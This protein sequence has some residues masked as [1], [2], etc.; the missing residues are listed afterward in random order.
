MDNIRKYLEAKGDKESFLNN[1]VN[2]IKILRE[3]KIDYTAIIY[4]ISVALRT[5]VKAYDIEAGIIKKG[6]KIKVSKGIHRKGLHTDEFQRN[7]AYP[8]GTE[9]KV[10][11]FSAS[12]EFYINFEK[13]AEWIGSYS[14]PY[15][16]NGKHAVKYK[17]EEL[18]LV[19]EFTEKD[20]RE[21]LGYILNQKI[22]LK[23]GSRVK[24]RKDSE[25]YAG[26]A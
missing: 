3:T 17:L 20:Y 25:F 2:Q 5:M 19:K 16:G 13:Q 14:A 23:K 21:F 10:Y 6:D 11:G 4:D 12:N 7:E 15:I 1:L 26:N 22:E 24:I 18:E 9:G 8:E